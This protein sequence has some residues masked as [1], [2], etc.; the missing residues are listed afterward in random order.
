MTE[1][2]LVP[3]NHLPPQLFVTSAQA[4]RFMPVKGKVVPVLFFLVST[5]TPL[6]RIGGVEV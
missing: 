3:L 6:R 4:I 1:N 2:S 5:T